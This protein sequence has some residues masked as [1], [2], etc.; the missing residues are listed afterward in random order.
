VAVDDPFPPGAEV[1]VDALFGPELGADDEVVDPGVLA[2]RFPPDVGK[3]AA[4]PRLAVGG[5]GTDAPPVA[6]VVDEG[7]VGVVAIE[8]IAA[9]APVTL[10]ALM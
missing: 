4:A 6:G 7:V 3:T 9:G 8:D 10:L 2:T 5:L 1:L